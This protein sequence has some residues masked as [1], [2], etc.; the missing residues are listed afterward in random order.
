M[1]DQLQDL[2]RAER[3]YELARDR[4]LRRLENG[5]NLQWKPP[6]VRVRLHQR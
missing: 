1:T 3:D 5:L 4:A 2:I 6:N